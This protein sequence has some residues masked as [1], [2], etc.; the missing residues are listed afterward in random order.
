MNLK[1][2]YQNFVTLTSIHAAAFMAYRLYVHYRKNK[3]NYI[4]R[5]DFKERD[6]LAYQTFNLKEYLETNPL[7]EF[8]SIEDSLGGAKAAYFEYRGVI[9]SLIHYDSDKP[10]EYT[11]WV[12]IETCKTNKIN[13]AEI[14]EKFISALGLKHVVWINRNWRAIYESALL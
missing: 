6:S 11:L 9:F 1:K 2:Y 7:V 10:D 5:D 13:L 3:L 12:D 14:S 4:L 8:E